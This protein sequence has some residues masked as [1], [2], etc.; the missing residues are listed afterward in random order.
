M[1]RRYRR[2]IRD[3]RRIGSDLLAGRHRHRSTVGRAPEAV[4]PGLAGLF[5]GLWLFAAPLAAVIVRT[6]PGRGH[7]RRSGRRCARS[8]AL[9]ASGRPRT[10]SIALV[11]GVTA[12]NRLPHLRL[13][14]GGTSAPCCFPEHCRR[15]LLGLQLLHLQAI[16]IAGSYGVVYLIHHRRLSGA[17]GRR[18]AHGSCISASRQNGCA[19]DKFASGR[20]VPA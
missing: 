13:P 19:L 4:V 11:Q 14:K 3:R 15:R 7:L 2:R 9:A 18:S 1:A 8:A 5:N 6:K 17:V 16:D 12:E 20:E 10:F